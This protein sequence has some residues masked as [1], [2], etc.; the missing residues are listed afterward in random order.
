MR[1]IV[2]LHQGGA[3][4]HSLMIDERMGVWAMGVE[5]YEL[6]G[7][8]HSLRV[9]SREVERRFLPKAMMPVEDIIPC[10]VHA[11]EMQVLVLGVVVVSDGRGEWIGLQARW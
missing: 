6:E 9:E 10:R 4:V 3:G 2:V 5:M 7:T 8:S 11:G 1:C